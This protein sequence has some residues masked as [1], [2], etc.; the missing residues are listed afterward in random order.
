[1]SRAKNAITLFMS[2]RGTRQVKQSL[3]QAEASVGKFGVAVAR[4]G[5]QGGLAHAV[6]TRS[7][8]AVRALGARLAATAQQAAL[9]GTLVGGIAAGALTR[10]TLGLA[11]AASEAGEVRSLFEQAFTGDA[12]TLMD[13]SVKELVTTLGLAKSELEQQASLIAVFGSKAN[14]SGKDLADFS[15]QLLWVGADL[16]AAF[17][18]SFEEAMTAVKS[19]LSGEIEPLKRFGIVMTEADL[20]ARSAALGFD[21]AYKSMTIDEKILVRAAYIRD[22]MGFAAGQALREA[23]N[24]GTVMRSMQASTKTWQ[25]MLGEP[26]LEPVKEVTLALRDA[27]NTAMPIITQRLRE[28]LPP[29]EQFGATTR[30]ILDTLGRFASATSE[31]GLAGGIGAVFGPDAR[32]VYEDIARIFSSLVGILGAVA[33]GI[34]DVFTPFGSSAAQSS[35]PLLTRLA[36]T[37]QII[38]DHR[39][40]IRATTAHITDMAP[41]IIAVTAAF[42]AWGKAVTVIGQISGTIGTLNAGLALTRG[43]LVSIA[44]TSD[45]GRDT[46]RSRRKSNRH[47]GHGP[48]PQPC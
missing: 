14:L 8:T 39:D 23:S 44:R 36:D 40:E 22:A 13:A 4:I 46:A 3:A 35:G 42:T 17:G 18:T 5:V 33:H 31:G 28:W 11:N 25:E 27:G 10:L 2:V 21:K 48:S 47:A 24:Y 37:L 19:G 12:L 7:A 9:F 43:R 6:F 1:M 32:T 30:R 41:K 45:Q 29:A 38:A 20:A 16:T 15:K 26:L 34:I